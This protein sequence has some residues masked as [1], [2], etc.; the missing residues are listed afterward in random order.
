VQRVIPGDHIKPI[1]FQDAI[2]KNRTTFKINNML[3]GIA[4]LL[5]FLKL[6]FSFRNTLAPLPSIA[7]G[8]FFLQSRLDIERG[9]QP[10][11]DLDSVVKRQVEYQIVK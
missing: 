1:Q 3:P 8:D 10:P 9:A 5:G 11:N 6:F 4:A 2:F 7:R